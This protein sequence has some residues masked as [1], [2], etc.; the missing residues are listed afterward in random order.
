MPPETN[1]DQESPDDA[2]D[3]S[4]LLSRLLDLRRALRDA[5]RP[6]SPPWLVQSVSDCY[7]EL[8]RLMLYA[9]DAD[10][11]EAVCARAETL[12]QIWT[13][14]R[15]RQGGPSGLPPR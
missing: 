5:L 7:S 12:L 11:A 13:S 15:S 14:Y 1:F 2:D 6:G 3:N 9:A 4:T 8:D 10:H